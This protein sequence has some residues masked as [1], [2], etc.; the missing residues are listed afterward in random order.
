MS[1]IS[2]VHEW[3]QFSYLNLCLGLNKHISQNVKLFFKEQRFISLSLPCS[4]CK[5]G[6]LTVDAAEDL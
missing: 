1:K 2:E 5:I 3:Y 4:E 6:V